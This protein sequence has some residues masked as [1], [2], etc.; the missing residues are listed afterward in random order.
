VKRWIVT[1]HDPNH[2]DGYLETKL[3][4]TRRLLTRMGSNLQVYH[5]Y[6]GLTEYL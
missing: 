2:D 3:N 5:G 6:D 1:H 4:Q